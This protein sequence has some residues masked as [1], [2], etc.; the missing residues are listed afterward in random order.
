[1]KTCKTC[2]TRMTCQSL[3]PEIES[4]LPKEYTGKDGRVEVSMDTD[5]FNAVME[6]YAYRDWSHDEAV[7]RCPKVDLSVFTAK[8]KSAVLLLASGMSQRGA[9]KRLRI[10]LSS[11]QKRVRTA[12]ARLSACQFSYLVKGNHIHAADGDIGEAI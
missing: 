1:M 9:A 12:R 10:K 3:C 5:A 6:R 7:S 11:L 4:R 8:E 2:K